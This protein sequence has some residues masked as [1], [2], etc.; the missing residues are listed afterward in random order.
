M[1]VVQKS[2]I[3][4]PA[5]GGTV[6]GLDQNDAILPA[7]IFLDFLHASVFDDGHALDVRRIQL[8]KILFRNLLPVDDIDRINQIGGAGRADFEGE[9]RMGVALGQ[10]FVYP[11]GSLGGRRDE[12]YVVGYDRLA[13]EL[14]AVEHVNRLAV[15]DIIVEG[16]DGSCKR[17]RF[18]DSVAGYKGKQKGENKG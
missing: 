6:F 10:D 5:S 9:L 13:F 1:A 16:V 7:F 17:S 12:R 2:A 8:L 15:D 18:Q 3:F 4:L 14:R 11:D